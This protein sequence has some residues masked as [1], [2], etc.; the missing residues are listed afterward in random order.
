VL[1]LRGGGCFLQKKCI[2]KKEKWRRGEEGR[3]LSHKL[4]TTDGF[5]KEII[6][7]SIPLSILSVK[8]ITSPY[9]LFF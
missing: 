8:S 2:R 4:N 7:P 1:S 5:T 6:S 9:D 3:S